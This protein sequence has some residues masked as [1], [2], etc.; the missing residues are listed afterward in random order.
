MST[1]PI[2]EAIYSLNPNAQVHCRDIDN[3]NFIVG[4]VISKSD[5]EAEISR[6]ETVFVAQAYSRNRKLE[7]DSLNQLEL[8]SDDAAGSTTTHVDAISAIKTKW[9]KNNTGPV[10]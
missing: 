7:Y 2:M 10:E 4:D 9:P 6:L 5:I 8:I 3:I 1:R